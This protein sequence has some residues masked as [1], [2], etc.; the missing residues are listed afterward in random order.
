LQIV[1]IQCF[2]GV[3]R[4]EG[5]CSVKT[6]SENPKDLLL[7]GGLTWCNCKTMRDK[8]KSKLATSGQNQY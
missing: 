2:R 3:W 5:I 8:K 4:Q 6:C 1:A 7:G